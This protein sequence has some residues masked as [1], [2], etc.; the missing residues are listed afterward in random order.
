MGS[1]GPFQRAQIN[2]A[3]LFSGATRPPND[4][5]KHIMNIDLDARNKDVIEYLSKHSSNQAALQGLEEKRNRYLDRIQEAMLAYEKELKK[6][7]IDTETLL[8][9]LEILAKLLTER[10]DKM[11]EFFIQKN[12]IEEVSFENE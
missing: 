11:D 2:S 7:N 4:P 1:V 6:K 5:H 9:D 3:N 8:R 12:K 10:N